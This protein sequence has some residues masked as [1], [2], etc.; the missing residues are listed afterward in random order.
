MRSDVFSNLISNKQTREYIIEKL[1]WKAF[2]SGQFYNRHD[3]EISLSNCDREQFAKFRDGEL[4]LA[5]FKSRVMKNA[6][7]TNYVVLDDLKGQISDEF[8]KPP[9]EAMLQR[10]KLVYGPNPQVKDLLRV[11]DEWEKN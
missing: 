3:L 11:L 2:E 9:S 4:S 8:L 10:I 5:Q 6:F 7:N 1:T